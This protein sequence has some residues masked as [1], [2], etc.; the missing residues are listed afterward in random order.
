MDFLQIIKHI[1]IYNV[2]NPAAKQDFLLKY[3]PLLSPLIVI[4][5]FFLNNWYNVVTK[6]KESKRNWYFKAYFEPSLKK[7][8][9]FFSSTDTIIKEALD[10]YKDCIN[11]SEN[12]RLE[13]I[14]S[15]L[16]NLSDSKRKF[17]IEVLSLLKSPYISEFMALEIIL[18]DFEDAASDAFTF[19]PNPEAYFKYITKI[20]EIKG[21]MI[22]T[23]SGPALA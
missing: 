21:K 7:V 14:G 22:D 1:D 2:T 19:P 4:A 6:K 3:L 18:N 23:L 16:L 9:D 11:W 8:D 5:T 10:T 15:K 20:N 12:N 13:F 17:S